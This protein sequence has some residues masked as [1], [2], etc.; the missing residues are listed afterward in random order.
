MSERRVGVWIIGA[1]GL[2]STTL[3][4]GAIAVK[5]R[6][7][8]PTGMLTATETFSGLDLVGLESI[9]F[10]GCDVRT[11]NLVETARQLLNE[12]GASRPRIVEEIEQELK[13]IERNI[14]MGTVCNCGEA[15]CGISVLPEEGE[16]SVREEIARVRE[17]IREFKKSNSI[18]EVVVVNLASTEPPLT[19]TDCHGDLDLFEKRLDANDRTAVRA[20][21][22]Y[23]YAA[24][25]EGCPY[26]NFTPS[27]GALIP[28]IITLAESNGV[29][30]MGND[31]K[32]GET[33]V[34]SA[35]AP[36]FSCRNLEIL[37]WEGFNI[38]GNM[39][40]RV[41]DHP[42]NRESKIKTKDRV[43]SQ[44]VGYS[45]HSRVHID[46]VPSLGDQKTAWDFVHFKGFLGAK[47]SLQFVWQ[48]FDSILAAPLVVDLVLFAE[49]AKRRGECGLMPH[50]A[51]Y[52]KAPVGVD[53][54]RLYEQFA[55]LVDYADKAKAAS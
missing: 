41:L 2:I 7:V 36:M 53:E 14:Q 35:L 51:S 46:Y 28:A 23:A 39:D 37:S 1:Y 3:M 38:L 20:S 52:F 10:G 8:E 26:I 16:R 49:L 47:M 11:G 17:C 29:P 5:R 9:Q 27:S 13:G 48:G 4:V 12:T 54:Y 55:M 45:P 33:L 34:K 50:L 44:I 24:V 19:L 22:I 30:V 25:L 15:I 18:S 21:T 43:L 31:G 6:L 32:T 40:G 42:E